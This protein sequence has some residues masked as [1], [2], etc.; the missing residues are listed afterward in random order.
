[1]HT[2]RF[3]MCRDYK[4]SNM[5]D[6][7]AHVNYASLQHISCIFFQ[8]NFH[9]TDTT[10]YRFL[11]NIDKSQIAR[12]LTPSSTMI[13]YI[14]MHGVQDMNDQNNLEVKISKI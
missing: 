6:N 7:V 12:L 3:L 14:L 13:N 8:H 5:P 11:F 4:H 10:H 1:M 9:F 2:I